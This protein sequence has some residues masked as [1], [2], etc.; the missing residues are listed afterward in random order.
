MFDRATD[1]GTYGTFEDPDL[2]STVL[3]AAP[4]LAP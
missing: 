1:S 4:W 2:A 3:S